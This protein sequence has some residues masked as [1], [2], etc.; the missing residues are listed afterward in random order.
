MESGIHSGKLCISIEKMNSLRPVRML[1]LGME[2]NF[3]SF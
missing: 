3:V 2:R 1:Q